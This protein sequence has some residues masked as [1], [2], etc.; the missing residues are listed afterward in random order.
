M[1]AN[2]R[3]MLKISYAGCSDLFLIISMQFT[4]RMFAAATNRKKHL[5]LLFWGFNVIQGQQ[6]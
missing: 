3:F 1:V 5:I 2:V 6:C 4:R